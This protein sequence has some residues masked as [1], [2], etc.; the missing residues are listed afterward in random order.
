MGD[1]QSTTSTVGSLY[2]PP[3]P[4]GVVVLVANGKP[5]AEV[6]S[7][8][9]HDSQLATLR[10]EGP[11]GFVGAPASSGHVR[12][13]VGRLLAAADWLGARAD[14]SSL[15]IGVFGAEMGGSAALAAATQRPD[16]FRAI[17]ARDGS[18]PLAGAALGGV[19]AATL[20]IV[21]AGDAA[22]ISFSQDAMTRVQGIAEIEILVTNAAGFDDP[23]T[24]AQVARLAR[25]WFTR[26]LP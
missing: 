18:P 22:A 12:E 21:D 8:S 6:L 5:H 14:L 19:R 25:R 16:A 24:R 11:D 20:L 10:L 4:R 9:L 23:E 7:R 17:V 26:F 3:A 15:P 13:I 1:L 2:V